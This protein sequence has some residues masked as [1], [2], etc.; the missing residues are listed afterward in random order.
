VKDVEH[1]ETLLYMM[2][3]HQEGGI[4]ALVCT[5]YNHKDHVD[6]QIQGCQGLEL[7]HYLSGLW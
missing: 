3:I 1:S 5:W 4:K 7:L 2:E 6:V